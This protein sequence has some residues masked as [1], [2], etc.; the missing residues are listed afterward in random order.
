MSSDDTAA[1]GPGRRP[2]YYTFGNHMHWVD[3]EWLWGYGALPGS[4]RDML[5]FCEAAGVKGNVNFDGVGYE[6]LAAEAPEELA[7]LRQAVAAGQIEVVGAS[8]G[9]PYGLFH[10]GES[11]VRQRVYGVRAVLRLFGVRPQ[12]FWEEEFDFFPQLPQLL[13]GAGYDYAALFFQWTWHTPHLP[14]EQVPAIWWEGMD[15]SRL[16][17]AP[18]GPL[19]LHQ[20][21]EDFAGLLENPLLREMPAPGIVQWLE[22]MPSPDW[23]C[24]AELLLPKLRELMAHPEFELR[25]V[26]LSEYLEAAR[27]HAVPRRYTLDDVFHGMS[28]GKNGDRMRRLSRRAEQSLLAAEALAA[29]YGLFGRPYPSWDV[30]PVWELEEAWRELLA[31]QHHDNDECEAL[32]GFVGRRSYER[33]LGLSDHVTRRTLRRLVERVAIAP[34]GSLCY[35]PLGWSRELVVAPPREDG[36]VGVATIPPFGYRVAGAADAVRWAPPPSVEEDERAITLRR[37]PLAVTVDRARG[38]IAQMVSAEFPGGL[39]RADCPLAALEM[40]QGEQVERFEH[41]DVRLPS[42]APSP[43]I[44]IQRRCRGSAGFQADLLV[45]IR[46]AQELDA[47]DITYTSSDLPRPDG[48]VHA[49]LQTAISVDLPKFRLIHDHPYGVS[50]IRAEGTYLR[51]YPTGDWMTSPQVFEE[52]RNP[53]TALQFLDFDGGKRGLLYLHDGSQ[54]MLRDEGTVYNILSMY[55]PWDEDGFSAQ[56]EARVR[57]VPHGPLTHAQRWRLAQ[58]FTRPVLIETSSVAAAPHPP[59]PSPTPGRGGVAPLLP[60][61][62]EDKRS[63]TQRV[64]GGQAGGWEEASSAPALPPLFGP[65][66]CDAPNVVVGAFFRESETAGARLDRY[67]G[68]GMGYPHILR[69]VELDGQATIA[70]VRVAGPVAAAYRANLLGEIVEPLAAAPAETPLAGPIAWS[71]LAVALRPYEIAT[72]YLD[73]ELGRKVGRDLDAH[74]SVW[75]TVHRVGER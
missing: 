35:N 56:L 67:A 73:L 69:L 45:S 19:N 52:V 57:L 10:G 47:I 54:A 60:P 15:G 36:S 28:L 31:A 5:F 63:A 1:N 23:M 26:T 24:R 12:S 8:Y 13:R 4:A 62:V 55:D 32:C 72:I 14:V 44:L 70:H 38:V 53:F 46:I 11:N 3:M 49:A 33:S 17:A 43:E 48:G 71:E 64:P 50:E 30:Y 18:R 16:L 22:L 40:T 68:T 41:V 7:A 29:T 51:K 42:G 39:L 9:Q 2:L 59:T 34:G 74:R 65:A 58:E 21:P 25:P 6:K 20:W 75:A 37:G 61:S 66:W 27:P